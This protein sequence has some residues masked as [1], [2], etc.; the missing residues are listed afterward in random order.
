MTHWYSRFSGWLVRH[1][2]RIKTIGTGLFLYES[3]NVL[4]DYGFY[5]FAILQWGLVIGSIIA[6][7]G[8][9][10][11]NGLMFWLYDRQGIDWLGAHILRELEA[12]ENKNRFERLAVWLGKAEK[13]RAEV[14]LAAVAFVG[15]LWRVDPLI[16]AVHFRREHFRGLTAKDWGILLAAVA[17]GNAWSILEMGIIVETFRFG[18]EAVF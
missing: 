15:L 3:Y 6:T 13:T 4:Y 5:A 16:V 8:S 10:I 7:L 1:R 9:L 17:V 2:V 14:V 11:Q 18:W 12:K